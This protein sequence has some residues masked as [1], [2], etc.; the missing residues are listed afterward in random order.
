[1]KAKDILCGKKISG[2]ISIVVVVCMRVCVCFGCIVV[3]TRVPECAC[4]TVH[5]RGRA[6]VCMR[7]GNC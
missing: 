5:V 4:V 6:C 7:E 3:G 2:L 1:M